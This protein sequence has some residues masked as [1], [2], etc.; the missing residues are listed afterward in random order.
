MA[1]SLLDL[2]IPPVC[3]ACRAQGS[4]PLCGACRRAL[5]FLKG[6]CCPRCA[7]PLPCGRRCPAARA[8]FN[9]AWAPF[10]HEGPARTVV[11]ALK[12]R[13][14]RALADVLAAPMIAGAPPGL[15]RPGC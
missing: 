4:W 12:Y 13:G 7:L 8:S 3:I 14:G 5:P 9:A 11:I 15:L 2:L 6:P 10:A 1:L